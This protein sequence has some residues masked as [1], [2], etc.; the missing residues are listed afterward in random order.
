MI[1]KCVHANVLCSYEPEMSLLL[2]KE[3]VLQNG[4]FQ[5][6]FGGRVKVRTALLLNDLLLI[7]WAWAFLLISYNS[8]L[9]KFRCEKGTKLTSC[10]PS[11]ALCSNTFDVM[12]FVCSIEQVASIK[13][14]QLVNPDDINEVLIQ[15][16][17]TSE[18]TFA[19]DFKPP[20]TALQAF[21][22][23]VCQFLA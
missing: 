20:Y 12:C 3:P 16:G 2:T 23:A 5:L 22:V 8:E 14:F 17:K 4:V 7:V 11:L 1:V 10:V 18:T 19:L 6:N 9:L 13:N 21:G 15:F